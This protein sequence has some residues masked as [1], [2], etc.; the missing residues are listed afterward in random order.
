MKISVTGPAGSG[1]TTQAK[2][3]ADYLK[4]PMISGG[5]ILRHIAEEDTQEGLKIRS[6]LEKGK[7]VDDRIMARVV[8][9]AVSDNPGEDF[10]MDGYPR[11]VAQLGE[12]D[13]GFNSVFYLDISDTEATERLLERGREDDKPD[14]IKERLKLFHAETEP[15]LEVYK[16]RG[17]L[18]MIDGYKSIEQIQKQ[19]RES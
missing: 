9:K 11:S 13:P 7:L 14:L 8:Q 17:I 19:I 18:K 3:L 6:D 12:F 10:V 4:V 1:K 16:K 5:T 15:L 2:L